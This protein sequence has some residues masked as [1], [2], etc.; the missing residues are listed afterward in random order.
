MIPILAGLCSKRGG[1]VSNAGIAIS[2]IAVDEKRSAM[3]MH[4]QSISSF[5]KAQR[6][7][8]SS[9]FAMACWC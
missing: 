4:K 9:A 7:H 3:L 6:R 2:V 1:E 5:L 8:E